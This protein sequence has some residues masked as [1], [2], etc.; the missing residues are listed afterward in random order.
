VGQLTARCTPGQ[1]ARPVQA[2]GL[3]MSPEQ[4]SD[5]FRLF[6]RLLPHV[7]GS[8]V[9]LYSIKKLIDNAGG[10]IKV[11]SELGVGSTFTVRLP[12]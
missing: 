9:G 2:N 8:G 12:R 5:L 11:A 6:R 7:E 10:T 3:G 4:L 1:V